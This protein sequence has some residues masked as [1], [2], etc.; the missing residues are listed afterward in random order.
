MKLNYVLYL[1]IFVQSVT[2]ANAATKDEDLVIAGIWRE[3]SIASS[4][5]SAACEFL[6]K[7]PEATPCQ[8]IQVPAE[9]L[10][11]SQQRKSVALANP[12]DVENLEQYN[13]E[14]QIP[15]PIPSPIEESEWLCWKYDAQSSTQFAQ[16]LDQGQTTL[17]IR[18]PSDW[19]RRR[20]NMLEYSSP[21]L[22]KGYMGLT[23][24]PELWR[25]ESKES[26]FQNFKNYFRLSYEDQMPVLYVEMTVPPYQYNAGYGSYRMVSQASPTREIQNY[27]VCRLDPHAIAEFKQEKERTQIEQERKKAEEEQKRIQEQRRQAEE[28]A[29]SA[30]RAQE[31]QAESAKI[32]TQIQKCAAEQAEAQARAAAAARQL[33][34]DRLA[35]VRADQEEQRL[36]RKM[37]DG[38][39]HTKKSSGC[40]L[41]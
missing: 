33:A 38:H 20:M 18:H 19:V 24:A 41:M 28:A 27:L 39:F 8:Q 26:G 40:N 22:G 1:S 3:F 37:G 7:R 10:Q 14:G 2:S 35:Q 30:K 9:P 5:T 21:V 6:G 23:A 12:F 32:Q 16:P 13:T 29:L 11:Q 34:E 25:G 17:I 36:R 15:I 4:Q 31:Q